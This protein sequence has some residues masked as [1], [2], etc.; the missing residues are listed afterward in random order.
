MNQVFCNPDLI[1]ILLVITWWLFI[2]LLFWPILDIAGKKNTVKSIIKNLLIY[3]TTLV[4]FDNI[5]NSHLYNKGVLQ[6]YPD[7]STTD[8]R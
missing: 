5:F 2:R 4:Q 6:Q 1:K 8:E 3:E 7:K